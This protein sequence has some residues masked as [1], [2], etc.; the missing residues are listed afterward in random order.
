VNCPVDTLSYEQFPDLIVEKNHN[1]VGY[2]GYH[3]VRDRDR[4]SRDC[5]L[6]EWHVYQEQTDQDLKHKRHITPK[7]VDS[8]LCEREISCSADNMV[9]NLKQYS[10]NKVCGLS[11]K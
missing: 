5:D 7:V 10:C 8:M 6:H 3:E 9:C 2:S 11:I 4:A 1:R